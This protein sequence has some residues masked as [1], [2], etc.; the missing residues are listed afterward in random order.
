[1]YHLSTSMCPKHREKTLDRIGKTPG[2]GKTEKVI[3]VA[4]QMVECGIDFSFESVIRIEAGVD[5]IIQ[6]AGRCNRSYEWKKICQMFIVRLK[7]EKLGPLHSIREAQ[8]CFSA[9]SH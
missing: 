7:N 5:S 3:C 2:L 4:T 8:Y 6:A 1:M 9:V